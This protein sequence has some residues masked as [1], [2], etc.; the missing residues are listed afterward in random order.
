MENKTTFHKVAYRIYAILCA[1]TLFDSWKVEPRV[2]EMKIEA[3]RKSSHGRWDSL[4]L[5]CH[6]TIVGC[7]AQR[8]PWTVASPFRVSSS[9]TVDTERVEKCLIHCATAYFAV[10]MHN[11]FHVLCASRSRLT[12][13]ERATSTYLFDSSF[14]ASHEQHIFVAHSSMNVRTRRMD[15]FNR[16]DVG[17]SGVGITRRSSVWIEPRRKFVQHLIH[18]TNTIRK[19]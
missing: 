4:L 6:H 19:K 1:S 13:A 10:E 8:H 12:Q 9:F 3:N 2:K 15:A 16:T 11:T 7:C 5:T 18:R 14:F 17:L